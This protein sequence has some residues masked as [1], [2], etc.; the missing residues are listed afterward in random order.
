MQALADRS[1]PNPGKGRGFTIIA[2]VAL[3]GAGLLVFAGV[4]ATGGGE[5]VLYADDAV[6][7]VL[8]STVPPVVA[9]QSADTDSPAVDT[10]LVDRD[11]AEQSVPSTSDAPET[12]STLP[13]PRRGSRRST[14]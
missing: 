14:T 13:A 8:P 2:V 10:E 3:V 4:R 6:A 7:S 11:I 5:S 12:T 9:L 1:E